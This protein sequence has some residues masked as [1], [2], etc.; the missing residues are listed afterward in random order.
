MA[1]TVVHMDNKIA[2]VGNSGL[3]INV[4]RMR[5]SRFS[6]IALYLLC[7]FLFGCHH[8]QPNFIGITGAVLADI[9]TLHDCLVVHINDLRET[10]HWESDEQLVRFASLECR[11]DLGSLKNLHIQNDGTI[12]DYWGRKIHLK[13]I[14]IGSLTERPK[15]K[16]WSSGSNGIDENGDGDDIVSRRE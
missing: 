7:Y 1:L 5:L 3:T 13:I 15:V 10:K 12:V 11:D 6:Q 4:I 2:L 16:I 9:E 8:K 14:T